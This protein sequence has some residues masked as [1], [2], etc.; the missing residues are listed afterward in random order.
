MSDLRCPVNHFDHVTGPANAP[1]TLLQYGDFH[2]PWCRDAYP[3]LKALRRSAGATMRMAFRHFPV[4][5][6]HR[7]AP[8]VAQAAES[9][10]VEGKFW[11]LH[12]ALFERP[13]M[14]STRELLACARDL[15]LNAARIAHD[16]DDGA[17]VSHV[18]SDFLS[19]VR[20][21]VFVTPTAFINGVRYN[22]RWDL[23]SLERAIARVALPERIEGV[24]SR[25]TSR[26]AVVRRAMRAPEDFRWFD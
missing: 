15:G 10:A 13:P 22:G 3:I 17:Y 18:A 8:P 5:E 6:F 14:V 21:G 12:A 4:T 2:C 24:V 16:L 25:V 20:S 11:E 26:D 23:E 1:V 7:S 19:G 9:A